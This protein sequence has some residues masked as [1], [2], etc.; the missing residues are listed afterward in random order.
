LV[1][2][3]TQRY[4]NKAAILN[5]SSNDSVQKFADAMQFYTL[6]TKT[7]QALTEMLTIIF[8]DLD[9]DRAHLKEVDVI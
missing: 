6:E 9:V 2:E 1:S 8:K 3:K 4:V 7:R 5:K